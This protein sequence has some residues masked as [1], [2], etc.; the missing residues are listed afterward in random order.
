MRKVWILEKFDTVEDM[1]RVRDEIQRMFDDAE[2]DSE[3]QATAKR[4]LDK[5]NED[6]EEYPE[7][8]WHGHEGKFNYKDF[9]YVAKAAIRRD[10]NAKFRVVAAEVED[11]AKYWLG[12]QNPVVNEGVMKY[13][14]ATA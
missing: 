13:L 9:C 11:D 4:I 5:C 14:Y 12:Y 7:G 10:R 8:R 3:E 1:T 2:P 6:L